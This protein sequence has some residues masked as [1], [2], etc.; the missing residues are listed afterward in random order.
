MT[1]DPKK[2]L[3]REDRPGHL[4][5]QYA[6]SLLEKSGGHPGRADQHDRAFV[7]HRAKEELAEELGEQGVLAMTSGQDQYRESA[8]ADNADEQGGP[9]VESP[10]G[11]EFAPGT[12]A[13]NPADA[14]REPLPKV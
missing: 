11:R 10:A 3:R 1:N 7:G 5:P 8:D 9:F 12:D 6:A 14:E 4:D 2:P 13:S